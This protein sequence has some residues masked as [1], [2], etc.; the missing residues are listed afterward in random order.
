MSFLRARHAARGI[1]PAQALGE[2][3]QNQR[4]Q[5][6]GVVLVRQR[7]GTAQGV[8]FMTIEDETGTV[9]IVIW[10]AVLARFRRAVMTARLVR[11]SGVVQRA[12]EVIHVIAGRIDDLS[13]ELSLLSETGDMPDT[14]A[15][16]DEVKRPEPGSRHPAR[17]SHPRNVR[18]L[19]RS[20]DFH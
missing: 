1:R 3:V 15:R 14:L 9:N 19:P 2:T 17:A 18:I 10:K 16:A 7:P 5:V 6:S 8:V 13:D 20:R 11:V 4:V 12:G